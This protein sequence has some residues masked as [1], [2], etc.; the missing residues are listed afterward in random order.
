M[1][2]Y[3]LTLNV[4]IERGAVF[5]SNAEMGSFEI[6]AA[7]SESFDKGIGNKVNYPL[8]RMRTHDVVYLNRS[9]HPTANHI[10]EIGSDPRVLL[11]HVCFVLNE[12]AWVHGIEATIPI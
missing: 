9:E 7:R 3:P 11:V 8:G 2:T 4:R 12:L 10:R 1:A 5:T 6:T